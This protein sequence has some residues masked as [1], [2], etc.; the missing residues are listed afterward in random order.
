VSTPARNVAAPRTWTFA[1]L[2]PSGWVRSA[3]DDHRAGRWAVTQERALWKQAAFYEARRAKIPPLG[4][5]RV[6]LTV[7]LR[8][9]RHA[10]PQ[11]YPSASSVKGLLD[12][13]V[14]ARVVADDRPPHLLLNMPSLAP[15]DGGLPRIVV[16]VIEVQP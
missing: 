8:N 15:L 4:Q 7:H 14:A 16:T 3:N 10:D 2:S 5:A 9:W 6:D 1:I 11:N 13:L 12:G